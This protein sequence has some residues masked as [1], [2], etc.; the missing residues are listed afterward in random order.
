ML[1]DLEEAAGW[2]ELAPRWRQQAQTWRDGVLKCWDADHGLLRDTV[3]GDSFSVHAQVQAVLAGC[4][5]AEQAQTILRRATQPDQQDGAIIITQPHTLFYR[6]HLAAAWRS[7]GDQEPVAALF[8]DWFRLLDLGISTWPENDSP[9]ARSDCHAWGCMPEI[10]LVHSIFGFIPTAPGW[11]SL[12]WQPHWPTL[13]SGGSCRLTIPSGE[14]S[15]V[16]KAIPT[17]NT[18]KLTTP[19]PTSLADGTLL[20]PG[21]HSGAS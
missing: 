13:A 19:V 7:C 3:D 17:G 6:S 16:V 8:D 14:I 21:R 20:P 18:W 9:Q 2:P 12:Q 11:T 4:W 15:L 1:A 10:E 5:P